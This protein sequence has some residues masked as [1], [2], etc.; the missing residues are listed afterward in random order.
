[1]KQKAENDKIS[2]VESIV[3]SATESVQKNKSRSNY[4]SFKEEPTED[5]CFYSPI[6]T[7]EKN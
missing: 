6:Q 7:P 1:M 3:Q 5:S 2:E 4:E